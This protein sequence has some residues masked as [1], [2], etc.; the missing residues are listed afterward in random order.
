MI[1]ECFYSL[2]RGGKSGTIFVHYGYVPLAWC[3]IK[4]KP[5]QISQIGKK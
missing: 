1:P 4:N 3:W 5:K 2:P